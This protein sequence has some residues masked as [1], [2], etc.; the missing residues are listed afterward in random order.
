S[1]D[2]RRRRLDRRPL[3]QLNMVDQ[4]HLIADHPHPAVKELLPKRA[5]TVCTSRP[6]R[7]LA[8]TSLHHPELYQYAVRT[9]CLLCGSVGGCKFQTTVLE[10][11]E[12][13]QLA[14]SPV[15]SDELLE[16]HRM[17]ETDFLAGWAKVTGKE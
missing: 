4:T 6:G 8:I 15:T 14:E 17:S 1:P 12:Q 9:R 7:G 3:G 11:G 13:E 2:G 5:G 10:P 16:V